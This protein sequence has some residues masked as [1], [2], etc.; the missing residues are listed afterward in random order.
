M[1]Y[2]FLVAQFYLYFHLMCSLQNSTSNVTSTSK[3]DS[4]RDKDQPTVLSLTLEFLCNLLKSWRHCSLL[5]LNYNFVFCLN[6]SFHCLLAKAIRKNLDTSRCRICMNP[7]GH[8]LNNLQNC[9]STYLNE[10]H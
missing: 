3:N 7:S 10:F 4:S 6:E 9:V 2:F 8:G 1:K 5:L